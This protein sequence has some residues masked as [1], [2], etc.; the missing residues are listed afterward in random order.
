M[1]TVISISLSCFF[2]LII[3]IGTFLVIPLISYYSQGYAS[4]YIQMENEKPFRGIDYS[5]YTDEHNPSTGISPSEEE[6]RRDML[7]LQSLTDR[8]RVYS[9]TGIFEKIP[10]IAKE[11]GLQVIPTAWLGVNDTKNNEQIQSLIDLA[12]KYDNIPFVVVGNEAVQRGD[13]TKDELI[14]FIVRVNN[15][16]DVPVT[17]SEDRKVIRDNPEIVESIDFIFLNIHPYND[18]KL[19]DIATEWIE[20][21][22]KELSAKYPNKKIII[23][24]TG[25]P[26]D[27]EKRGSAIPSLENQWRFISDFMNF[28]ESHDIDYFFFQVFDQKI[29]AAT[30]GEAGANWGLFYSNRIAKEGISA[31]L[32]M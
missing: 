23:S 3:I 11:Y 8:I 18:G 2:A 21:G 32:G 7:L 25:W 30:E 10:L 13:L 22:Y 9:S 16:V 12:R 26:T 20:F 6:I 24:E 5:P 27:G 29:K 17:T 14:S 1:R 15:S 28:S 4:S 19:V 31:Y